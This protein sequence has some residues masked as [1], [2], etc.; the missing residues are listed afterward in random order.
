MDL[1]QFGLPAGS[2]FSVHEFL[3]AIQAKAAGEK[4]DEGGGRGYELILFFQK[5]LRVSVYL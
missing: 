1:T 5:R 4:K 3:S 2:G